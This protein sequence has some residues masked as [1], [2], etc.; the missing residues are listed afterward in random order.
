[1]KSLCSFPCHSFSMIIVSW[2][3][4]EVNQPLKHRRIK[5]AMLSIRPD[6]IGL[7][8]SKMSDV[9]TSI[10]SH[11]SGF[12]DVGFAYSPSIECDRG[13]ICCWNLI[14]FRESS[15]V[16]QPHFVVVKRSR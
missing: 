5:N 3:V 1:M 2:N 6:W 11:I 16:C 8:N 7:Q 13:I 4:R 12:Q 14:S 15:R 9:N 10:I